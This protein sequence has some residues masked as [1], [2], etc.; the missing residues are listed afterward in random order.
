MRKA[1]VGP[2]KG[3]GRGTP[4]LVSGGVVMKIV[5]IAGFAALAALASLAVYQVQLKAG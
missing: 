5:R 4:V 1:P 2:S 3:N